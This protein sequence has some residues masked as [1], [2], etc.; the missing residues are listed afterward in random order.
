MNSEKH[1]E[2]ILNALDDLVNDK[3][4]HATQATAAH[5]V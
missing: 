2:T 1:E 4:R 5:D 3:Y